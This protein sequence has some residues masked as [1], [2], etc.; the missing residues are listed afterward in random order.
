MYFFTHLFDRFKMERFGR[1]RFRG[2]AA[3]KPYGT[4]S[5]P[6]RGRP[7]GILRGAPAR[8]SGSGQFGSF[9]DSKPKRWDGPPRSST[10][11]GSLLGNAPGNSFNSHQRSS[12][13]SRSQSASSVPSEVRQ[14]MHTLGLSQSDMEK[15]SQLPENE[16]SVNNLAKA[17]GNLKGSKDGSGG[18]SSLHSSMKHSSSFQRGREQSRDYGGNDG[19]LGNPPNQN[20][21]Q[22]RSGRRSPSGNRS[23]D[24]PRNHKPTGIKV[25][26]KPTDQLLGGRSRLMDSKPGSGFHD[27]REFAS[28]SQREE[29]FEE[30]RLYSR[31]RSGDQFDQPRNDSFSQSSRRVNEPNFN[32]R[33][34]SLIKHNFDPFCCV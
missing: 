8:S 27:R 23:F 5:G 29:Y 25:T 21:F 9:Q 34:V 2:A 28:K 33:E 16:L 31:R 15:L 14:L 13:G 19:I 3:P 32:D 22:D 7:S 17:I 4:Q 11:S 18:M 1:P 10:S 24:S 26:V 12:A 6:S 30:Q 20:R